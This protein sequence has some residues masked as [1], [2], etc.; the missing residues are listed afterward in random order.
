MV[1]GARAT[2]FAPAPRPRLVG[3][4]SSSTHVFLL[5]GKEGGWTARRAGWTGRDHSE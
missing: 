3:F 4:S 5:V 2:D 1:R